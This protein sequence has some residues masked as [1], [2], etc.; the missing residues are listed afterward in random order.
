MYLEKRIENLTKSLFRQ[1]QYN[2]LGG[3]PCSELYERCISLRQEPYKLTKYPAHLEKLIQYE[4]IN[5]FV[6][7]KLKYIKRRSNRHIFEYETKL[8]NKFNLLKT[9]VLFSIISLTKTKSCLSSKND[10]ILEMINNEGST[11]V[12]KD[13]NKYQLKNSTPLVINNKSGS[14]FDDYEDYRCPV[15]YK[16]DCGGDPENIYYSDELH[17]SKTKKVFDN[18][19]L[20]NKQFIPDNCLF[21]EILR[22]KDI[23]SLTRLNSSSERLV[24]KVLGITDSIA[25]QCIYKNNSIFTKETDISTILKYLFDVS[26]KSHTDYLD[27]LDELNDLDSLDN[28]RTNDNIHN[29]RPLSTIF[30]SHSGVIDEYGEGC[31]NGCCCE[32]VLYDKEQVLGYSFDVKFD[33]YVMNLSNVIFN[34]NNMTGKINIDLP[35]KSFNHA[36]SC[37]GRAIHID[38]INSYEENIIIINYEIDFEMNSSEIILDIIPI[39]AV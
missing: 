19:Q 31:G 27:F 36:S 6:T 35:S 10:E 1:A 38:Y 25:L 22:K 7:S 37:Q 24:K 13:L 12:K 11:K 30:K 9:A 18:G 16:Y 2:E 14:H 21:D 8:D 28:F 5:S 32:Y 15:T 34:E 17:Y 39:I 4:T 33:N 3:L 20:S 26:Y 23:E 29:T